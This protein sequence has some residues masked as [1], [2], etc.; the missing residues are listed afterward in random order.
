MRNNFKIGC[1]LAVVFAGFCL[2][3]EPHAQA[4]QT[5]RLMPRI[6]VG[7][8]DAAVSADV[9][10]GWESAA[11]FSLHSA[12][13]TRTGAWAI[14][15]PPDVS[16]GRVKLALDVLR[17]DPEILWIDDKAMPQRGGAAATAGLTSHLAVR[18]RNDSA[19]AAMFSPGMTGSI[20]R[21]VLE[22]AAV[23]ES[24]GYTV[25]RLLPTGHA[26]LHLDAPV[27]M[28]EAQ[29][30]AAA[31]GSQSGV[32]YAEAVGRA[33]AV[34][35]P[36]DPGYARQWGL[37]YVVSG[38]NAPAAWNVTTGASVT[39]AVIDTGILQHPDLAGKIL[40]G[41]DFIS[42][43]AAARD[44]NGRDSD[45]TDA[46]DASAD[47]DECGKHRSSWHGTFVSGII[48][49]GTNNGTGAAGVSWGA[50]ILP[51]RVLGK[52]GGTF[53]D[54]IDGMVWAS[55]LPVAGVPTNPYPARILNMSLGAETGGCPDFLQEAI[56]SVVARGA[57]VVVAAGNSQAN[58]Y[59]AAPAG[60]GGVIGV[61]AIGK[62]G[63]LTSYSNAGIK[64]D[65]GAPGGDR[66]LDPTESLIYGLTNLGTDSAGA[67]GYGFG[68]GTSFAAPH[69]AGVL[70]LMLSVNPDLTPGQMASVLVGSVRPYRQGTRCAAIIGNGECGAGTLD[71]FAALQSTRSMNTPQLPPDLVTVV[72]FYNRFLRHYFLTA[73][74]SEIDSIDAGGGGAGWARTGFNFRAFSTKGAPAYSNPVCRFYGL[75]GLGPNSHFYTAF[76]SECAYIQST[77]PGWLFEGLAFNVVMPDA[78]ICRPG[79]KPVYRSYNGLAAVNDSNHRYTIDEF[80][81]LRM[82]QS[83]W[84]PEG[85]V[86]C[87]AND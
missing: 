77:D 66:S 87:A 31:L 63:D 40:P 21:R 51:V 22:A 44:G 79:Y 10:R 2:A 14:D 24:V 73:A 70:A 12:T 59:D 3:T 8:A 6:N 52:C 83:G 28:E 80:E 62:G 43:P 37:S 69:V 20:A 61:A 33:V 72:E 76:P 84:Q 41:Y 23:H 46:G 32:V 15:V 16:A 5:L 81:Y 57:I 7:N 4:S 58:V 68:A 65:L 54:V 45:P 29:Q 48:A 34:R 75:P 35:A 19:A 1:N 55:G 42:D 17:G 64:A 47:N 18:A 56:D 71:A 50:K 38:I 36:D 13:R 74:Q 82:L 30:L 27:G 86:M 78:G 60:C 85:V 26:L 11:G 39:V 67:H 25:E 49:A 9:L 53:A